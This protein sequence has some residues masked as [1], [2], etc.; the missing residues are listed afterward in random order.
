MKKH[1][2]LLTFILSLLMNLSAADNVM[3]IPTLAVNVQDQFGYVPGNRALNMPTVKAVE[4]GQPF[5]LFFFIPVKGPLTAGLKMNGTLTM[6]AP[7]GGEK[8]IFKDL[9]VFELPVGAKG[10]CHSAQSVRG[11]FDVRDARGDYRW[12]LQLTPVEGTF[13]GNLTCSAGINLKSSVSDRR[14]MTADE[15]AKFF[16]VYYRSPVPERILAAWEYYMTTGVAEQRKREGE[17]FNPLA[18]LKGFA[19][20][21]RNNPQFQDDLAEMSAKCPGDQVIF[22]ALIFNSIGVDD[23]KKRQI[24]PD[25]RVQA[26]IVSLAGCDPLS[27]SE[28]S[29]GEHLDMLWGEFFITGRFEPVL[30]LV[31]EMRYRPVITVAEARRRNDAKQPL[32]QDEIK[33]LM[34]DI[35]KMA[36]VWSLRSNL[37]QGEDLLGFYMETIVAKKLYADEQTAAFITAIFEKVNSK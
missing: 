24:I 9:P 1:L 10:F 33:L 26:E 27:I 37:E 28:I 3:I 19:E 31:N 17:G 6:R 8:V 18:T 16:R 7:D 5:E 22:Y 2:V 20:L 34:N 21:F 29:G 15:F 32:T 36:A 13:S 30:R 23:L 25:K 12:T 11:K 35:L 4:P 14:A